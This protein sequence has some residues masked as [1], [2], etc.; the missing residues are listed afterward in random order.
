M[1]Q[2]AAAGGKGDAE[3]GLAAGRA[4]LRQGAVADQQAQGVL[5]TERGRD[6]HAGLAVGF[7]GIRV[8]AGQQQQFR[9]SRPSQADRGDQRRIDRSTAAEGVGAAF[10]QGDGELLVGP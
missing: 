5:A 4:R 2:V 9:Q 7:A 3:R 8:G 1:P 10:E 6:M